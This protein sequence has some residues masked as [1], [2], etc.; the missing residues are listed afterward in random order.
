MSRLIIVLHYCKTVGNLL[1]SPGIKIRSLWNQ[2]AIPCAGYQKLYIV[3]QNVDKFVYSGK[4]E[5]AMQ[6]IYNAPNS[7]MAYPV[8]IKTELAIISARID[9]CIRQLLAKRV[10]Y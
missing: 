4:C 3:R 5:T 1:K 7:K 9:S 6:S 2:Q 10:Y 8:W